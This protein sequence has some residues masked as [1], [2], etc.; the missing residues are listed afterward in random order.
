MKGG[1]GHVM[2]SGGTNQA[3]RP[4]G[5]GVEQGSAATAS[6]GVGR[7]GI[8]STAV[9]SEGGASE[10][11]LKGPYEFLNGISV[12]AVQLSACP[13]RMAT[14]VPDLRESFDKVVSSHCRRYSMSGLEC[15]WRTA[16]R[17]SGGRPRIGSW[18]RAN[19][20]LPPAECS[21]ISYG[22]AWKS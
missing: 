18:I 1:I 6:G 3:A 20:A 7:Q 13:R 16:R 15:A 5:E 12:A 10:Q 9:N 14:V 17:S 22:S 19:S 11:V 4:Q 8:G 2:R 21:R